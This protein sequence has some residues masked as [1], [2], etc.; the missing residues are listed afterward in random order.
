MNTTTNTTTHQGGQN[1]GVASTPREAEFKNGEPASTAQPMNGDPAREQELNE[2]EV[3]GA[4]KPP[5]E[6]NGCQRAAES[7]TDANSIKE[8]Q[9]GPRRSQKIKKAAPFPE[10]AVTRR[11]GS[12]LAIRGK[13]TSPKM[14]EIYC[15]HQPRNHP[16]TE[17]HSSDRWQPGN[18]PT[19]FHQCDLKQAQR[20]ASSPGGRVWVEQVDQECLRQ[21]RG[22]R[23]ARCWAFSSLPSKLLA[24]AGENSRPYRQPISYSSLLQRNGQRPLCSAVCG[25]YH[26]SLR[27]RACRGVRIPA[28]CQLFSSARKAAGILHHG[29]RTEDVKDS[30]SKYCRYEDLHSTATNVASTCTRQIFEIEF[31]HIPLGENADSRC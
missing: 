3:L 13:N 30:L 19:S 25:V 24:E 11:S 9:R 4:L 23:R 29:H 7:A 14:T 26:V 22:H 5:V 27:A 21:A 20:N 31:S 16:D 15:N 2:H 8:I 18:Q 17:Q 10:A 6:R 12:I 28:L 1:N